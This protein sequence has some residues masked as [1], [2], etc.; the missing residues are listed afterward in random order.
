MIPG[1]ILLRP[2]T[3]FSVFSLYTKVHSVIHDSGSVPVW[4]ISSPQG[5]SRTRGDSHPG[6]ECDL[7]WNA[8]TPSEA[9]A[10]SLCVEG[11][12]ELES[13]RESK[14]AREKEREHGGRS[15]HHPATCHPPAQILVLAYQRGDAVP[16]T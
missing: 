16:D 8:P 13:E 9:R 6:R 1:E 3:A 15:G 14:R 11:G 12:G 4:N 2:G 7:V 5:T 10:A